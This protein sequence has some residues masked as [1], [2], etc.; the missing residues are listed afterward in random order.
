MNVIS[1]S[2]TE[3]VMVYCY[4]DNSFELNDEIEWSHDKEY[5]PKSPYSRKIIGSYYTGST[6]SF[7]FDIREKTVFN[8]EDVTDKY[9]T[10]YYI[11]VPD[12]VRLELS[13]TQEDVR[14]VP[15]SSGGYIYLVGEGTP[16][17]EDYKDQAIELKLDQPIDLSDRTPIKANILYDE[18]N[19]PS[20]TYKV[21]S[22]EGFLFKT[23]LEAGKYIKITP[24][25]STVW[26]KVNSYN[27][28]SLNL[29]ETGS[30]GYGDWRN[31]K[32]P[33][34]EEDRFIYILVT[35][36]KGEV[37]LTEYD[38]NEP[39]PGIEPYD[40]TPVEY[41]KSKDELLSFV[42]KGFAK[43]KVNLYTWNDEVLRR[44]ET[45]CEIKPELKDKVNWVCI[46]N[47][48]NAY[49]QTLAG[50]LE[51]KDEYDCGTI[52]YANEAGYNNIDLSNASA[53]ADIGFD[54]DKY[55]ST[56]YKYV[57]DLGTYDGKLKTAAWAACP[58]D[59][60]FKVDIAEEVLGT[61][62]PAKVQDMISTPE[63]FLA[64]AEKMKA[65]GYFM[66]DG[67]HYSQDLEQSGAFV[68]YSPE[69]LELIKTLT[70]KGYDA[71]NNKWSEGWNNN[72]TKYGKAFGYFTTLW[73]NSFCMYNDYD[74][75]DDI[76]NG[77]YQL[78]FNH[79]P[80]PIGDYWGGT[81]LGVIDKKK[82][83]EDAAAILNAICTDYDVQYKY[84]ASGAEFEN[85][86]IVN[87][88][89]IK[90]KKF[91]GNKIYANGEDYTKT[92][93]KAALRA[94]GESEFTDLPVTNSMYPFVERASDL[95]IISGIPN[96]RTG[97]TKFNPVKPVQRDQFAIMLF[98]LAKI[99]GVVDKDYKP[100]S[101][102]LKDISKDSTG[103][104]AIVWADE[105][106]IVTGFANGNFKP[107]NNISRAQ[108][109]LM[110]MRYAQK[111]G[112]DT[113]ARDES[114]LTYADADNIQ[115][116]FVS[117]IEWAS[118]EG[119]MSGI[120]KNGQ[121]MVNPNGNAVRTQCA[122]FMIKYFDNVE[123]SHE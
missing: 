26:G 106:G 16:D 70:E 78:N 81:W 86:K 28:D 114:I 57:K 84:A 102:K 58:L 47:A 76:V 87:L 59:F 23:T 122:I 109:T 60:S 9:L 49:I 1:K 6:Y 42:E 55:N 39:D 83:T 110:L 44:Y 40:P 105:N 61:S 8:G 97:S 12:E 7:S 46:P 66:T 5:F 93:H 64:V 120:T 15:N 89:L 94:G 13:L 121:K 4:Q 99:Q 19:L 68:T 119:I 30:Y 45:A 33:V 36:V 27:G 92:L 43:D 54:V 48:D 2:T 32:F 103:Y 31:Y 118:A 111:Y 41:P 52:I 98:N 11:V 104:E 22:I 37:S 72:M 100:T 96:T 115:E 25:F 107:G 69:R 24:G 112:F 77:N 123:L 56:S 50:L 74:H 10:D 79:C 88:N 116:A 34:S 62:D 80:G 85:N 67:E 51:Y 53:L 29:N 95:G 38:P 91:D 21:K 65:A 71:G 117:S 35:D 82:N 113:S 75:P 108:I 14:K 20:R 18:W 90:E 101:T 63:K 17:L 3:D 73:F